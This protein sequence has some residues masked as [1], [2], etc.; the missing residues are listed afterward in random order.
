MAFGPRQIERIDL[1]SRE[2]RGTF[3]PAFPHR[4]SRLHLLLLFSLTAFAS[5]LRAEGVASPEAGGARAASPAELTTLSDV[6]HRTADDYRRWAYTEHRIMRDEKGR[7]KSDTLV[8]HDPSKPYAEQWTPLK[9]DGKDPSDRERAKYRRM[10][11]Q[12]EKTELAPASGL[13]HP[14][15]RRRRSL[16]E[17]LDVPR[18]SIAA[19]TPSHFV[20]DIPLMKF[21]NER[22]PP[23][24]FQVLARV[25]KE[26]PALE[27]IAVRL[28]ESFRAKLVVKVKSGEGSL[29]FS[30]VDPR[31]PPVLVAI[32]GDAVASVLFVSI[33]GSMELKRGEL[34]HV[35]PFDERFDVQIGTLKAI[36]L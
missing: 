7:V 25:R 4:M 6:L 36:D 34:K 35:K 14:D 3:A 16:G 8:R 13:P 9:I 24:K 30:P 17:V 5:M 2:A 12:A 23:E 27:N 20:F 28:R 29:D 26:G 31:Y 1:R 22:F 32:A 33:G 18:S 19:E 10:G 21:G 15:S 11:E